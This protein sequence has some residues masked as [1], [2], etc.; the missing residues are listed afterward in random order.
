MSEKSTEKMRKLLPLIKDFFDVLRGKLDI[1]QRLAILL[2]PDNPQTTGRIT[3]MQVEY[4]RDFYLLEKIYPHEFGYMKQDAIE[5]LLSSISKHGLGREEAIRYEGAIGE[6][7]L[8][9]K[10]GFVTERKEKED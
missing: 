7:K 4:V 8:L 6:T 1:K 9:Q 2:N 5:L 3:P 10:L